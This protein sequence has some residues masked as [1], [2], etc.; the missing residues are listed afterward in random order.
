MDCLCASCSAV[1]GTFDHSLNDVRLN[2]CALRL[3]TAQSS[4]APPLSHFLVP[5]LVALTAALA[6][7]KFLI[8]DPSSP[9]SSQTNIFAWLFAPN[10]SVSF[11]ND[12]Q[13]KSLPPMKAAKL[14]YRTVNTAEAERLIDMADASVEEVNLGEGDVATLLNTLEQSTQYLPSSARKFGIWNVG[15]LSR[16]D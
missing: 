9:S 5:Q 11:A 4:V 8:H 16:G 10:L 12:S 3:V 7:S 13:E 2:K 6:V 15:I 1:L 14:F